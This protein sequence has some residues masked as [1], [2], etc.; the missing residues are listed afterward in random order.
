M[1]S[2]KIIPIKQR[3]ASACGPTSIEMVLKYFDIPHT[4]TDIAKVTN[5]KKEDGIYNRQL[6]S[7]LQHYGL[8]TKVLKNASWENLIE[9]N[10][11]DSVIILSWMLDGYI[12]DLSVLERKPESQRR[13]R[14]FQ[15]SE[16]LL[17]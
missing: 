15:Q 13:T 3:D 10:T 6:V 5:Y 7:V 9:L 11:K 1:K 8:R 16:G 2:A 4:V 17:F 14:G 12:G